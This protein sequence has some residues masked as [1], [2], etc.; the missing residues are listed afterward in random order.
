MSY[1]CYYSYVFKIE[2]RSKNFFLFGPSLLHD[3]GLSYY[4]ITFKLRI[5][6]YLSKKLTSFIFFIIFYKKAGPYPLCCKRL[7]YS[8]SF[9]APRSV[10]FSLCLMRLSNMDEWCGLGFGLIEDNI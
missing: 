7:H 3:C 8:F 5:Q 6:H 10:H 4:F 2:K 9:W 1:I